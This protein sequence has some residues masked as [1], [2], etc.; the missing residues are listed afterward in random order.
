M[1]ST[2]KLNVDPIAPRSQ[3]IPSVF[4]LVCKAEYRTHSLIFKM[5]VYECRAEC[6]TDSSIFKFCVV[7]NAELNVVLIARC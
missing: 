7:L 5:N 2:A 6:R 3:D 4:G 1:F